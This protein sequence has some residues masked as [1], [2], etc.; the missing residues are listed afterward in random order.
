MIPDDLLP[1][2]DDP[3]FTDEQIA[4]LAEITVTDVAA[5]R[6]KKAALLAALEPPAPKPGRAK[7]SKPAP[8]AAEP[9]AE[10]PGALEHTVAIGEILGVNPPSVTGAPRAVRVVTRHGSVTTPLGVVDI[11]PGLVYRGPTAKFLWENHRQLVE[12]YGA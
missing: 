8:A 10:D 9:V 7:P 6:A 1:M 4:E 11:R 5:A 3:T 12:P 2:L